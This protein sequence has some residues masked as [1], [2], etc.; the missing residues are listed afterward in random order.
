MRNANITEI[1]T[2]DQGVAVAE[3][4]KLPFISV[5]KG[6]TQDVPPYVVHDT[7]CIKGFFGDYR[8]LSNFFTSPVLYEGYP[9]PASE[10]AYQAAKFPRG[11]WSEFTQ[12]TASQS[13]KLGAGAPIDP[14]EW[15]QAKYEI[16]EKIVYAKFTQSSALRERL[17]DTGYRY[18]EEANSWGDTFWGRCEGVG[19]NNLGLILMKVR[20]ALRGDGCRTL[21]L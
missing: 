8:F 9:F 12:M 11:R 18:L 4:L 5:S 14:A 10:N 20:E 7:C 17:L 19:E 16:M 1:G 15:D 21:A 2:R 3:Q 6:I 13:K